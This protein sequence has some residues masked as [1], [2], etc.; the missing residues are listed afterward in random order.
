MP[1]DKSVQSIERALDIIEAVAVEQEGLSL[2]EI[3][4][5]VGLHKST[6]HRIIAT[7]TKRGYLD[8]SNENN[9]RVGLKLI[10]AVSC[11]INS[12]ELQTEARPYVAQ[13]TANLGLTSHLG[14]LDGDKVVYIEKMDV[15]SSVKMYS[16]I[17][18]RMHA[19]CSSLGKC[20]LANYSKEQL[21][22]IMTDCGFI[23]FTA[24]TIADIDALHVEINKVRKQG[25]AMDDEEYEIGHRCI[26]APIY[27]YRGDIIAAISASGDKH[28]LTDDRIEEV[29]Q[30]VMKVALEISKGMGYVE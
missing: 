9:Y 10:E 29:S 4:V 11:Y 1:D 17:G 24:N 19:Y 25:W 13:I 18:L 22:A 21:D 26:G 7:L 6:A 12:L 16:Q 5:K 27:D 15:V 3:A 23:K 2:T 30:Y 20:L 28:V 14:V 8:K